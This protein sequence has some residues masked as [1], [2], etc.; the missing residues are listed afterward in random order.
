[1]KSPSFWEN[2]T[3]IVIEGHYNATVLHNLLQLLPKKIDGITMVSFS[4]DG[5]FSIDSII[6]NFD[7]TPLKKLWYLL[8]LFYQ[9]KSSI[10][11]STAV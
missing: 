11:A 7:I 6:S 1:M 2:G 10:S 9:N 4:V 8:L 3:E 5:K